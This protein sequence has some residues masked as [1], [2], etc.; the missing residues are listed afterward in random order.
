M[1]GFPLRAAGVACLLLVTACEH[2]RPFE[3]ICKRQCDLDHTSGDDR[4][5]CYNQCRSEP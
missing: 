5:E 2:Y 3:D 1:F 4:E